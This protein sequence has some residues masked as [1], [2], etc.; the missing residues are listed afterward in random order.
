MLEA[1][2]E[3][4]VRRVPQSRDDGGV[5]VEPE[6]ADSQVAQRGHDAGAFPVLTRELSSW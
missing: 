1:G 6:Q 5:A 4:S 2:A 3:V